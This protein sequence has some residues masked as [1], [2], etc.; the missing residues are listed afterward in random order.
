[1]SKATVTVNPGEPLIYVERTFDAPRNKV[2]AAMTDKD[3]IAKWWSGGRPM[4]VEE[5]DARDGGSWKFVQEGDGGQEFAFHGTYHEVSPE[6]V[7]QTFEFDGLG[8]RGHVCMEKMELYEQEDGKT[9]LIIVSAFTSVADRD[10]MVQ[11]GME[12]GMNASYDALE[13][14]LSEAQ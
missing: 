11:S 7:I 2:F 9:K 14:I 13:K 5:F 3:A 1:M 4:R 8:E 10:G 6:R 12:D